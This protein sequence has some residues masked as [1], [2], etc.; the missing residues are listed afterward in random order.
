VTLARIV[1]PHCTAHHHLGVAIA[2][3]SGRGGPWQVV[4]AEERALLDDDP[5]VDLAPLAW[6]IPADDDPKLLTLDV[7]LLREI[8][9]EQPGELAA[10]D[11][12]R[13]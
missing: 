12:A 2:R 8:C 7:E 4:C 1:A 6:T 3:R 9:G 10:V 13:I 5:A 11:A